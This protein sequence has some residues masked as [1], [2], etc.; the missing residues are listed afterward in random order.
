MESEENII[1]EEPKEKNVFGYKNYTLTFLAGIAISN[2]GPNW[3]LVICAGGLSL[4]TIMI[5]VNK[6]IS[7]L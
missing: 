1:Q 5:V 4:L 3:L 7:K 2:P 6:P